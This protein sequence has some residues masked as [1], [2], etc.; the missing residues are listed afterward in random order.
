MRLFLSWALLC[1]LAAA[2]QLRFDLENTH[3]IQKQERGQDVDYNRLRLYTLV[4]SPK[5]DRVLFKAIVDDENRYFISSDTH[6]NELSLYRAYLKYADAKNLLVIGRQRIPFGVGRVWN[7]VDI[8][9][10]IDITAI[11]SN[12]REGTDALHYEY[13]PGM[14]SNIDATLSKDK[15]ALRVK[16]YL[17]YAD[18]ALLG[19]RDEKNHRTIVGYEAAGEL[20]DTGVELRSEGG[21]FKPETGKEYKEAIFGA[22]YGFANSL[23]LLGEYKYNSR[24]HINYAA[25]TLSYRLTPLLSTKALALQNLR[26]AS[27]L[28]SLEFE[29]S[30][31]D[32]TTL[33][34]GGYFYGGSENSEYGA[35]GNRYY[36]RLFT[37][38]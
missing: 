6:R 18:V 13:A 9:N 38:F 32:E 5:Y 23:T 26:D 1:S 10:P 8:Y 31:S 14:L 12:E 24:T 37:H 19:L 17:D 28:S 29:Y 25:A 11:E 36:M 2:L 16:G 15:M 3:I 21:Y 33:N 7:P 34:V 20:G 35:Q 30:L 4:T 22:E 27:T